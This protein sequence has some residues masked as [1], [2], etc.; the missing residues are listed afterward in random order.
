M[1]LLKRDLLAV[2][3]EL[4]KEGVEGV[5][6]SA[7]PCSVILVY[8]FK[9]NGE[10]KFRLLETSRPVWSVAEKEKVKQRMLHSQ[11]RYHLWL[12][13]WINSDY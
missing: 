10:E 4:D 1:K 5:G 7:T 13:E 8:T 12:K 6:V 2:L 3:Q 9:F 11:Q